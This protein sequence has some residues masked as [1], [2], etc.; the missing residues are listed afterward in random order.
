MVEKYGEESARCWTSYIKQC[1]E[2]K[3]FS[4]S[5][6]LMKGSTQLL[7]STQALFDKIY[8]SSLPK[9]VATF[10]PLD[11]FIKAY[12][13]VFESFKECR[14]TSKVLLSCNKGRMSWKIVDNNEKHECEVTTDNSHR[15][16]AIPVDS[17]KRIVSIRGL[18]NRKGS[19]PA[20]L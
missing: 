16:E 7:E 19:L 17:S 11:S 3:T 10:K 14:Y 12:K 5:D 8:H 1:I 18:A 20:Y 15:T 2:C 13:K 9:S 6:Q 4:Y